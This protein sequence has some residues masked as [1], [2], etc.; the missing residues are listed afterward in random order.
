MSRVLDL[1]LTLAIPSQDSHLHTPGTTMDGPMKELSKLQ[2]LTNPSSSGAKKSKTPSVDASLDSL[3]SSLRDV[4]AQVENGTA[5]GVTLAAL[6]KTVEARKK[7]VDEKQKEV[8]NAIAKLG[9]ALDKVRFN[10][11]Y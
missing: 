11:H 1:V 9:K 7:E 2:Q 3:L 10:M 5:T 6:P 4:R 8:Y